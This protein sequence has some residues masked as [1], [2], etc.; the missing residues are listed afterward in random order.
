MGFRMTGAVYT[1]VR[2]VGAPFVRAKKSLS[3]F[4]AEANR[5]RTG[6]LRQAVQGAAEKVHEE[7]AIK[8]DSQYHS[9]AQRRS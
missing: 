3:L 2:R 1:F 5:Q 7:L 4:G 8:S 6:G 9:A